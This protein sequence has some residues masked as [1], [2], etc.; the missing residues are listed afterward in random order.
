MLRRTHTPLD[1][2]LGSREPPRTSVPHAPPP[3]LRSHLISRRL[4]SLLKLSKA[5]RPGNRGHQSMPAFRERGEFLVIVDGNTNDMANGK[6]PPALTFGNPREPGSCLISSLFWIGGPGASTMLRALAC[7]A[8]PPS[9]RQHSLPW[10]SSP[11]F[12]RTRCGPSLCDRRQSSKTTCG[13]GLA[14][15]SGFVPI[16]ISSSAPSPPHLLPPP[17]SESSSS[18][19]HVAVNP[20]ERNE[21][22]SPLS[23]P[24]KFSLN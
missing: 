19:V 20:L 7:R 16:H 15:V 1:D 9:P 6:P 24:P 3:L 8:A 5:D 10:H 14:R 13:Q 21:A 4:P 18:S 22:A 17:P 11:G 2:R 12:P 23:L